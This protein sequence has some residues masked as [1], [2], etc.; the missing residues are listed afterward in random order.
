MVDLDDALYLVT[1][2]FSVLTRPAIIFWVLYLDLEEQSIELAL[3]ITVLTSI[4]YVMAIEVHKDYYKNFFANTNLFNPV[5]TSRIF[6]KYLQSISRMG[7][8]GFGLGFL[9]WALLKGDL[10]NALLLG[11]IISLDYFVVEYMRFLIFEKKFKTWSLV[12]LIRYVLP[13]LVIFVTV[14][15]ITKSATF[16]FL[17]GYLCCLIVL[18]LKISKNIHFLRHVRKGNILIKKLGIFEIINE[19]KDR[20]FYVLAAF[21]NRHIILIDRYIIYFFDQSY[22]TFYTL[23]S[24]IFSVIPMF[25]DMFFISRNRARFALRVIPLIQ[26]L[27]ELSFINSFFFSILIGTVCASMAIIFQ[28]QDFYANLFPLILLLLCFSCYSIAAPSYEMTFWHCSL[29]K[30]LTIETLFCL[31][32][33]LIGLG[34]FLLGWNLIYFLFLMLSMHLIRLFYLIKYLNLEISSAK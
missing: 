4:T 2:A 15:L 14:P 7:V 12:Q 21:C 3:I 33:V 31:S 18:V 34:L 25:V 29:Q 27:K 30:R 24:M 20:F 26:L 22:F 13:G 19:L 17:I 10:I 16:I 11:L 1:R 9:T 6:F 32:T 23:L 5:S 8:L 28:N